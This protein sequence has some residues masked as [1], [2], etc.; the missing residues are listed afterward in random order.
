MI[1]RR[2]L[3]YTMCEAVGSYMHC[4]DVIAARYICVNWRE[5][6][7]HILRVR[8]TFYTEYRPF[9]LNV[10][11]IL[12]MHYSG[13]SCNCRHAKNST[14]LPFLK[15]DL[16]LFLCEGVIKLN[17]VKGLPCE[18]NVSQGS[19]DGLVLLYKKA[20]RFADRNQYEVPEYSNICRTF[21][22]AEENMFV[23]KLYEDND[24]SLLVCVIPP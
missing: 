4:A 16:H 7:N 5:C 9:P 10:D 13:I 3:S 8:R 12:N 2:M 17:W 15:N 24:S 21:A 19:I 6:W 18:I 23:P 20:W 1:I 22:Y 11:G 14:A